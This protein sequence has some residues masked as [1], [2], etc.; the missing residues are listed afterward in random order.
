MRVTVSSRGRPLDRQVH[1]YAEYRIFAA[2]ATHH[3]VISARV[4]L[5]VHAAAVECCV[6]VALTSTSSF[7]TRASAAHA[8]AAID[9]AAQRVAALMA[10]QR[11]SLST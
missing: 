10:A 2:L 5:H 6:E 1:C 4:R 11:P 3:D 7:E 8:A 9:R